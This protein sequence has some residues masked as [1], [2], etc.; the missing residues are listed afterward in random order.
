MS[1]WYSKLVIAVRGRHTLF[2]L[3]FTLSGT[4]MAWFH[5]LDPNYVALVAAIQGWV[6]AHSY[7]EDKFN[8]NGPDNS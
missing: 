2:A 6:F 8:S 5:R 3:F 1:K 4:A 7:K